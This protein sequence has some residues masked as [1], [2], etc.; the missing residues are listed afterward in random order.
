M[1]L[2]FKCKSITTH[3][4]PNKCKQIRNLKSFWP[5]WRLHLSEMRQTCHKCENGSYNNAGLMSAGV[6]VC[7][8]GGVSV[9]SEGKSKQGMVG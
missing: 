6:Y 3:L 8:G 1:M 9:K 2:D 7:V 5:L 4:E